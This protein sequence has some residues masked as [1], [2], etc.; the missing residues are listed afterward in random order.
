MSEDVERPEQPAQVGAPGAAPAPS[1]TTKAEARKWFAHARKSAETRNYDYA[2]E[3]YVNGLALWPNAIEEGLKALRVAA[4]ARRLAGGKGAGFLAARKRP[5]GGKDILKSLNNA[6]YLFGMDPADLTHMEQILQ[7]AAKARC[8]GIV[9]WMAPIVTDAFNN[10][11]KLSESRYAGVCAAMDAGA[12]LAMLARQDPAALTILQANIA[13]SQIWLSHH[14]A[15]SAAQ[16][17]YS[18]ASGKITI[19]KGHFGSAD[20]FAE[21]LKDAELQHDLHDR[22]KAVHSEDRT[23]ELIERARLEWESHRTVPAKLIRL[24]ELML[25]VQDDKT[26]NEAIALLEKEYA[27]SRD[28]IFK[29]KADEIRMRQFNRHRRDLMAKIKADP[30]SQTL[31]RDFAQLSAHQIEA[32][33]K[34]YEDR[35]R[36]YPSDMRVRFMLATRFFAAKRY[37]DAIPLFQHAQ[38]DG[39]CRDESRLYM[40]RCFYEKKFYD[41]AVGSL[42]KAA[43]ELESKDN[44]MAM[45]M[46]YWLA[47]AL[48]AADK[49]AEAKDIYGHLIQLEY[50]YQ[51]ARQR[52]EKLTAAGGG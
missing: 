29:Q 50:N 26:E 2:I 32:E 28:Y 20:G 24:V 31:R 10:S 38:A 18:N 35:Q 49:P 1:E 3:L 52:L 43:E 12:D 25:R 13:T 44:P 9:Q 8:L 19:V 37:D 42:R 48:E 40:G 30:N 47:R 4:T 22:D 14:P 36:Q 17:A 51:D 15:S 11:K 7:L 45:A 33:I 6:L 39:R 21:S 5:V 16:K 23:Q 34:I 46:Q 27:S 41:Q